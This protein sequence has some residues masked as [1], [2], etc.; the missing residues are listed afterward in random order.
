MIANTTSVEI[1]IP[2]LFQ[3]RH[4][5]RPDVLHQEQGWHWPEISF[6]IQSRGINEWNARNRALSTMS[7]ALGASW[8]YGMPSMMKCDSCCH[9]FPN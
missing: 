4:V 9:L 2:L 1:Q 3:Q 8:L 6:L 7:E 5:W